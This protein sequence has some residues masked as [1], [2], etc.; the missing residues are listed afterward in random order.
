MKFTEKGRELVANMIAEHDGAEAL[1]LDAEEMD[2]G[3]ALSMH[4][5]DLQ[6]GDRVLD[7]DGL[8]VVITQD[9]EN[10]L[11]DV[12]FDDIDGELYVGEENGGCGGGC[13]GCGGGCGDHEH[14]HHHEHGEGC[15][16]G[17][18]DDEDCGCGENCTCK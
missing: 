5:V 4:I 15:G 14:E 18:H 8:K 12:V 10:L 3:L 6:E 1:L 11:G 7:F 17:G 13:G 9:L 2:G 16:C